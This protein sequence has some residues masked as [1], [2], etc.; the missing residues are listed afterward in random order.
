MTLLLLIQMVIIIT[1]NA[2][3][4]RR[5][6]KRNTLQNIIFDFFYLCKILDVVFFQALMIN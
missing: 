5:K 1:L 3:K 6:S 2:I 4:P